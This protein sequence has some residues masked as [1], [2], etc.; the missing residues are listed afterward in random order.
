VLGP[1]RLP[2]VAQFLGKGLAEFRRA[3]AD[4]TNELRSAQ[5]AI[6]AEARQ[7]ERAVRRATDP[8]SKL[9]GPEKSDRAKTEDAAAKSDHPS[10]GQQGHQAEGGSAPQPQP[11]EAA[12][13]Q[14]STAA[15][16]DPR[17]S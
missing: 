15:K 1:K 17:K 9:S 11:D 8:Q 13:S 2:E 7:A 6:N 12:A 16:E 10:E 14:A 5:A 3:T 4:V